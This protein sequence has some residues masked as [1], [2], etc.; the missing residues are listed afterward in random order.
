MDH[1]SLQ[2]HEDWIVVITAPF[3]VL[4]FPFI[5]LL[6]HHHY[7]FFH[8][9]TGILFLGLL[10]ASL[11]LGLILL[12]H[13]VVKV[14]LL[15]FL[16]TLSFTLQLDLSLHYA[17]GLF[18]ILGIFGFALHA[19]VGTV[20]VTF[21]GVMALVGLIRGSENISEYTDIKPGNTN[22]PVLIHLVLDGHIGIDGIPLDVDGGQGIKDEV[23]KFYTNHGF[24]IYNK[25]YSRYQATVNSLRNLFNFSADP[26]DYFIP[27]IGRNSVIQFLDQP[28][29]FQLLHDHGYA[30]RIMHPQYI[31]Y[32]S[33]N[34]PWVSFCYRYPNL[35]L[36]SIKDTSFTALEKVGLMG[37]VLLKRSKLLES[38]YNAVR[39]KFDLPE[40]E[41]RK[42]PGTNPEMIQYLIDDISQHPF[43]YAYIV[44]LLIPH[45][46]YVYDDNCVFQTERP[47]GETYLQDKSVEAVRLKNGIYVTKGG[48]TPQ[49]RAVRY[50]NDFDQIRCSMTWLEKI[51]DELK[52]AAVYDDSIIVVHSDHGPKIS[53]LVPTSLWDNQL[54]SDD[55]I[56]AYSSMF[57]VKGI[58]KSNDV[59]S[60]LPLEKI[61]TEVANELLSLDLKTAQPGQF[62]YLRGRDRQGL[63]DKVEVNEF[64]SVP[65]Q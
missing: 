12:S 19:H 37:Q 57:A 20:V 26:R 63:L 13:T 61:L 17:A 56:D 34:K 10:I 28:K 65:S 36:Q 52:K 18:L 25:A 32:C 3:L 43:G 47:F 14:T 40:L 38:Y 55:Y 45:T 11:L 53:L 49:S 51:L 15:A 44:H 35:N 33:T 24:T 62:V 5:N 2:N 31:D 64:F 23:G 29:Y 9:E 21:F 16:T 46:P 7:G 30:L 4:A 6:I 58:R 41:A 59:T 54:S 27:D 50:Q 48:N 22:L 1:T 60:F 42:V 8:Y 39:N